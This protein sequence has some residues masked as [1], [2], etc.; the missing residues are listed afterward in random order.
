VPFVDR[1]LISRALNFFVKLVNDAAVLFFITDCF[2]VLWVFA[3][4]GSNESNIRFRTSE[5]LMHLL[6]QVIDI[7]VTLLTIYIYGPKVFAT[8]SREARTPDTALQQSAGI[9]S[10]AVRNAEI[11]LRL[12]FRVTLNIILLSLQNTFGCVE[13]GSDR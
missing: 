13:A 9:F 4:L 10:F 6:G 8:V 1:L 3:E 12:Q 2:N 5:M 11:D 7:N